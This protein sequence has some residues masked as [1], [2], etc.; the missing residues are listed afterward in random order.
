MKDKATPRPWVTQKENQGPHAGTVPITLPGYEVALET[1]KLIASV[2]GKEGEAEANASLIVRAV[3][4]DH[5]FD[6]LVEALK[7][8]KRYGLKN[9]FVLDVVNESL[10]LA[11]GG[12]K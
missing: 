3:N 6:S 4:R 1:S 5:A 7:M 11:E 10:R 2:C 8:V 12:E 9:R